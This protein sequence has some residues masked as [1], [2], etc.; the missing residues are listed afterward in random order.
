LVCA[1]CL[2]QLRVLTRSD[3]V[4]RFKLARAQ[5]IAA[6]PSW[7]FSLGSLLLTMIVAA[8]VLARMNA[9]DAWHET[10][11]L[12]RAI[13]PPIP[14]P[15]GSVLN[16]AVEYGVRTSRIGPRREELTYVVLAS[17]E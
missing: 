5:P 2:W 1:Y 10:Q 16:R 7:Q 4:R 13:T 9:L 3:T 12:S 6:R 17:W 8:F 11:H 15:N 14:G